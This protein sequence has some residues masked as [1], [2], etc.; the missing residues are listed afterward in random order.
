LEVVPGTWIAEVSFDQ[1]VQAETFIQLA[2]E[3]QPGIRADGGSAEL[4]AKLGIER[5]ANR[6]SFRVTHWM[7]PSAP[8]RHSRNPRFLQALSDYDLVRSLLKTKM[9]VNRRS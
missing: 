9:R 5:E 3:Q 2:R 8:A 7:M 4:D 1:R 6:A